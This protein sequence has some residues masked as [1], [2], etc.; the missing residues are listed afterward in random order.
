MPTLALVLAIVAWSSASMR[1]SG[2]GGGAVAAL[3]A[4]DAVLTGSADGLAREAR[5]TASGAAISSPPATAPPRLAGPGLC[6]VGGGGGEEQAVPLAVLAQK[7]AGEIQRVELLPQSVDIGP[8]LL[9]GVFACAP[10]QL[11]DL[12]GSQI[13]VRMAKQ[14]REQVP[15][16]SR[17]QD[18]RAG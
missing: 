1:V 14:Y 8:Q 18:L 4:V 15:L 9:G 6:G 10:A 7:P 13:P 17:E 2:P 5:S 3:A 16:L 12:L 11:Q